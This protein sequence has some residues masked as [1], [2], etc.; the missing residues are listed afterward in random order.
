MLLFI[1]YTIIIVGTLILARGN[2]IPKSDD[3]GLI[4]WAIRQVHLSPDWSPMYL[5]WVRFVHHFIDS[6]I[7]IYCVILVIAVIFLALM[8]YITLYSISKS[9]R[10][11]FF[12]SLLL[13]YS[14]VSPIVAHFSDLPSSIIMYYALSFFLLGMI[15]LVSFKNKIESVF[16]VVCFAIASLFRPE[17]FAFSVF[18]VIY[19]IGSSVTKMAHLKGIYLMAPLLKKLKNVLILSVAMSVIILLYKHYGIPIPSEDRSILAFEQH[20]A[21]RYCES[22][23]NI[24]MALDLNQW[25]DWKQIFP[26]SFSVYDQKIT[27]LNLFVNNPTAVV[28]HVSINFIQTLAGIFSLGFFMP[29][30]IFNP[31]SWK[32]TGLIT[33]I[34]A[35]IFLVKYSMY[36][37]KRL[38]LFQ[39]SSIA[40][41]ILFSCIPSILS[42]V[43]FFPR[44]HYIALIVY[45]LVI[46]ICPV[47]SL[48]RSNQWD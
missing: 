21:V 22:Y 43:L 26:L 13:F 25:V 44:I 33:G 4:D 47:V 35:V 29:L 39:N 9:N 10:T 27:F 8:T 5:D 34:L 41:L 3:P 12:L 28:A 31:V 37:K 2:F 20:F 40:L 30:F 1:L 32:I 24:C 48:H 14:P 42:A 7:H 46:V 11:S 38:F 19:F 17:F 36:Y 15:T 18:S 6:K 16:A 45:A 23:K